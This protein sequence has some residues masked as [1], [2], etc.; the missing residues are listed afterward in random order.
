ME[1][2]VEAAVGQWNPPECPF[3]IEYSA[4]VLDDIRLAVMDAFFSLPRGG[5]E[6]GGILLGTHHG[7]LVSITGYEQLDCEHA[8]GPSFLLSPRDQLRLSDLSARAAR[9]PPGRQLLGW[10]HSH[11]RSEIFLSETDIDIHKRFFWEPWHIALV[12]KP[13]TF[14]PMRAGFFFRESDGSIR[15]DASYRIFELETLPMLPAPAAENAAPP[16][17]RSF[18]QNSSFHAPVVEEPPVELPPPVPSAVPEQPVERKRVPITQ[19]IP[20]E[21]VEAAVENLSPH[22]QPDVP[23]FLQ[24]KH[25]R[26]WRAARAM[27]YLGI[28]LALGGVGFQTRDTWLPR[29]VAKVRP[30]LPK[31]PN[32]NLSLSLLDNGGQLDIHWDRRSPAIRNALEATLEI[33]DGALAPQNVRL[34]GPQLANGA[35]SYERQNEHVEVTLVAT[36]PGGKLIQGQTSFLGKLP[37]RK[38]PAGDSELRQE[39]DALA[40]K[41]DQLQ[42]DVNFQA[43]KIRKMEKDLKDAQDRL[44]IEQRRRLGAQAGDRGKKN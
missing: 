25:E 31:D 36:E 14:E 5:A 10:Y 43:S 4:R 38:E 37:V 24:L 29:M 12:L 3:R 22:P 20:E 40:E 17:F 2:D 13:H 7:D 15:G 16:A 21:I 1:P 18:Q 44:E 26:S 28:G 30:S 11:T 19:E 9:N 23:Q 34:D 6:I 8:L 42:K 41:N 32:A 35:I 33:R 27:A 39:R